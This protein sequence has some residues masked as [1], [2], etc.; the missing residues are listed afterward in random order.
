MSPAGAAPVVL[1]KIFVELRSNVFAVNV[2]VLGGV[3]A[4]PPRIVVLN[5]A[6]LIEADAGRRTPRASDPL[7]RNVAALPGRIQ[8]GFGAPLKLSIPD[9]LVA[10]NVF[11]FKV[12]SPAGAAPFV[13]AKI[14][15]ELRSNVFAVIV[16]A[17][18]VVVTTPAKD[19]GPDSAE[20]EAD[21][22]RRTPGASDPLNRNVAGLPGRNPAG[23]SQSHWCCRLFLRLPSACPH[24][25]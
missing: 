15:V 1:A 24:S 7:N 9:N 20:V 21:A 10:I 4:L 18:G 22:G 11:T 2:M 25:R 6:V 14:C 3:V 13:L 23:W 8:R 16:M 5:K 17:L 19:V 12:M